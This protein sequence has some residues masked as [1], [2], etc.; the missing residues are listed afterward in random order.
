MLIG[1]DMVRQTL[2][3][4]RRDGK[5]GGGE[6]GRTHAV[7]CCHGEANFV[8][9]GERR[10]GARVDVGMNPCCFVMSLCGKHCQT[11]GETEG[12][13][14]GG[15]P[16]L[17]CCHGEANFVERGERREGGGGWKWG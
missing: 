11:C 2:S 5:G 12:G 13:G 15:E 8:E 16:M 4:V 7:L 3:N 6:G 17:F 14:G 9:R 10:E 1:G